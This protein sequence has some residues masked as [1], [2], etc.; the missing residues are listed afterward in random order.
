[1]ATQ[2]EKL[3]NDLENNPGLHPRLREWVTIVN[4]NVSWPATTTTTTTTTA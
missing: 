2:Y 1:M 3:R 4:D